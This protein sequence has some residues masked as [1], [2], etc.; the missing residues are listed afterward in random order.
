VDQL[1]AVASARVIEFPA[2]R[3]AQDA[4]PSFLST[5]N[6]VLELYGKAPPVIVIAA[7]DLTGEDRRRLNG[8]V[9]RI[10]QK[11]I[12][13]QQEVLELVRSVT[14]QHKGENI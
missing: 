14:Q 3:L 8:G 2:P 12:T 13:S 9:E 1:L 11:G 7:K 6:H 5:T 10:I 4:A